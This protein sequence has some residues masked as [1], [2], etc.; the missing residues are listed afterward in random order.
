MAGG[1]EFTNRAQEGVERIDMPD[2]EIEREIELLE[3]GSKVLFGIEISPFV[4]AEPV[5]DER[6]RTL[7]DFF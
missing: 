1:V 2:G 7:S 3:E 4:G 6:K 5:G